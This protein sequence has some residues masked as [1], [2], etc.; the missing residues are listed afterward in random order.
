MKKLVQWYSNMVK[1]TL[2][3]FDRIVF[4]GCLLPSLI[5]HIFQLISIIYLDQSQL[6]L[7]KAYRITCYPFDIMENP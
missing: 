1:D 2:S 5:L 7:I 3:G 4:K 6:V